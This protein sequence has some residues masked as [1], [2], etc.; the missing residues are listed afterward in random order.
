MFKPTLKPLI[1]LLS[2]VGLVDDVLCD[3]AFS[4][5]RRTAAEPL[6]VLADLDHLDL[7]AD[8]ARTRF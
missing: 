3:R 5:R 8:I 4:P 2:T 6:A 7:L 1:T